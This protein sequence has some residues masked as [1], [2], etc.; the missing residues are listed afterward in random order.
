MNTFIYSTYINTTPEKL[1]EALTSSEFTKQ[2][3]GGLTIETDWKVGSTIRFIQ[4]E[5]RKMP[6]KM[7]KVLK[8]DPPKLLSYT[9]IGRSESEDSI[10]TFEI[11][12]MLPSQVRLNLKHEN[13]DENQ[14]AKV[15]EGWYAFMSS[16]KT[17]LESGAALDFSWWRG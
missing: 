14:K 13:I 12:Q 5:F 7:G 15:S 3:W 16:L 4:A 9:G 8:F 2:Y 11:I 10:V 17:L 1:W 6:D